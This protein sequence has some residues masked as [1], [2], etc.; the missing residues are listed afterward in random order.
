LWHLFRHSIFSILF[1]GIAFRLSFVRTIDI[2][3]H[4]CENSNENLNECVYYIPLRAYNTLFAMARWL[5]GFFQIKVNWK[6]GFLVCD[7]DYIHWFFDCLQL[8]RDHPT[9]WSQFWYV[10]GA[11]MY[12][13]KKID[14]GK[15]YVSTK[16]FSKT[17][18]QINWKFRKLRKE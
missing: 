4:L 14:K 2:S 11:F 16:S 9:L 13:C 12:R 6:Y 1:C 5:V 8:C 15:L 7:F 17:Q 18:R 10:I 3:M